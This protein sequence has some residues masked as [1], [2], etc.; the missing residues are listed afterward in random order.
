MTVALCCAVVLACKDVN[1]DSCDNWCKWMGLTRAFGCLF[2]KP[3]NEARLDSRLKIQFGVQWERMSAILLK[4]RLLP[5]SS[6]SILSLM[7][8][9]AVFNIDV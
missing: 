8:V 6:I 9:S 4:S 7:L 1:D 3:W 2:G 5:A